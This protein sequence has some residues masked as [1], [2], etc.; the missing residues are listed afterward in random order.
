M[1]RIY[2]TITTLAM[3]GALSLALGQSLTVY[4]VGATPPAKTATPTPQDAAS[5][6]MK[7]VTGP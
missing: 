1:F 3:L 6:S 2:K 7:R 5:R 4:A